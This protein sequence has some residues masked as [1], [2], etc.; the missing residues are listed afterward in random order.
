MASEVAWELN[1]TQRSPADTHTS[2]QTAGSFGPSIMNFIPSSGSSAQIACH[3]VVL[4][5]GDSNREATTSS[6]LGTVPK[7]PFNRLIAI[8][9][10][11]A[12]TAALLISSRA[13]AIA[14]SSA[15]AESEVLNPAAL[16]A[17]TSSAATCEAFAA[18]SARELHPGP[19]V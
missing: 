10:T 2:A 8:I 17:T 5:A 18:S 14:D 13:A 6:V 3:P 1:P 7:S 19:S 16:A 4:P 15:I 9:T 11:S 12:L